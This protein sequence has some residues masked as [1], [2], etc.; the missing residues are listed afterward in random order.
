MGHSIK[1]FS[2]VRLLHSLD[3]FYFPS[4]NVQSDGYYYDRLIPSSLSPEW[5]IKTAEIH[6]RGDL[7]RLRRRVNDVNIWIFITGSFNFVDQWDRQK[8][9]IAGKNVANRCH[10]VGEGRGLISGQ[11]YLWNT[12]NRKDIE[13]K[14]NICIFFLPL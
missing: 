4:L 7:C 12:I 10:F 8:L 11:K 5:K 13:D 2:M 1:S 3:L 14:D 9:P 6:T